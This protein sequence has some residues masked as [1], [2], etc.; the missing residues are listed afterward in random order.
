MATLQS[1]CELAWRQVYPNP[2]DEAAVQL[3]EFIETGASEYA[4]QMLL[5]Y[6]KEKR[7]EGSFNIPSNLLSTGKLDVVNGVADISALKVF[8]GLPN[9]LWLQNIGGIGSKCK[10]VK[11]SVNIAQVL[12]DDDSLP[13]NVKTYFPIGNQIQFPNGVHEN[14]VS[15]IYANMGENIEG[16]TEID[17]TIAAIV[18]TRLIEIYLGKENKEDVTNNSNSNE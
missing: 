14:P 13:D 2:S 15:I 6:W 5:L 1:V 11:S 8:R 12:E 18:R 3:E 10:Y 17:D 4:Y 16:E 7:E 9:D